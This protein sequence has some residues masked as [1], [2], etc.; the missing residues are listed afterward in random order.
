MSRFQQDGRQEDMVN[1]NQQRSEAMGHYTTAFEGERRGG[2][3]LAFEWTNRGRGG[4]KLPLA[5]RGDVRN[6]S[7]DGFAWGYGGSG[8]AQ[9]ALAMCLAAEEDQERALR[10]Y[11]TVK[12]RLVAPLDPDKGWLLSVEQVREAIAEALQGGK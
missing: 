9:L 12:C 4:V 11:Q 6:H 3:Y 10:A 8:P 5:R 2:H 1:N 7:P